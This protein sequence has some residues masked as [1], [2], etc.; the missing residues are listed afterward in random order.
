MPAIFKQQIQFNEHT[1]D[2]RVIPSK[3]ARKFHIRVGLSGVEVIHPIGRL[4]EEMNTFVEKNAFWIF[5][6]IKR[7]ERFKKIR[8][9]I[10]QTK[11]KILFR[12]KNTTIRSNFSLSQGYGNLVIYSNNE[13]HIR[14]G[15]NSKTAFSRSL[16]IWLRK[17]ARSQIERY[18]A[19]LGPSFGYSPHKV[20]IM[21]QRTKWGNCS[22][23]GNL[24][25]NW[26]LIL[27]PDFVMKYIVIH[28]LV[29]LAIPSHSNEFWL[30]VQ[31]YCKNVERAR[32]WLRLNGK[33]LYDPL[34]EPIQKIED[35]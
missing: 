16:E 5:Q 1:I 33:K 7:I 18:L 28:E 24:S 21:G 10:C 25:F 27:A 22:P 32:Q 35:P 15:P 23:K 29:H 26:R 2:F 34:P 30:T 13:I 4:N 8:H 3:S 19:E 20:Y 6:Q 11:G 12:G 9:P 14:Y 17:Q 31:S